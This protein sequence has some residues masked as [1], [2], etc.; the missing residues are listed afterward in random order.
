MVLAESPPYPVVRRYL[1]NAISW[2]Y[3]NLSHP[4]TVFRSRGQRVTA[5]SVPVFSSATSDYLALDRWA[6]LLMICVHQQLRPGLPH[7]PLDSREFGSALIFSLKS[8]C[9]GPFVSLYI[10]TNLS[11]RQQ[12]L[13]LCSHTH[14]FP[15]TYRPPAASPRLQVRDTSH[16]TLLT[17]RPSSTIHNYA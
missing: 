9:S 12:Q 11:A 3:D 8:L 16:Q 13:L 4:V 10:G 15:S 17:L 14:F 5:L 6:A 1:Y 7:L 2:Q